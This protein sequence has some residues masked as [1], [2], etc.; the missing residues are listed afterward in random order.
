MGYRTAST[1]LSDEEFTLINDYCRRKNTTPSALI[2][3]LIFEE[4]T[5]A[6]PSHIAGKNMIEYDKKKDLFSW[7]IELDTGERVT[8][9]KSI[10]P[11]YL[12]DLC[13]TL[14]SALTSR[15]ELQRKKRGSSVPVPR[16]IV[17]G[18]K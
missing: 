4:I 16:K 6:V 15:N 5:P 3:E 2:K 1:R 8:A 10:S 9:L 13:N 7:Q 12:K 11:E 14:A 17:R 18:R